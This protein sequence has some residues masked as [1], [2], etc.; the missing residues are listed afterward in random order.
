MSDPPHVFGSALTSR[1]FYCFI[2]NKNPNIQV[3]TISSI[4]F[5]HNSLHQS[6]SYKHVFKQMNALPVLQRLDNMFIK[7]RDLE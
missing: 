1:A 3:H 7:I 4:E 5:I 2:A 6:M